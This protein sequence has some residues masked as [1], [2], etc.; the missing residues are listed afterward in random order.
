MLPEEVL[1]LRLWSGPMYVP[2]SAVLRNGEKGKYTNTLH[3]LDSAV[4]SLARIGFP[5]KVFR[6]IGVRAFKLE[7]FTRR[8][9][10][11]MGA[12][13][14]IRDQSV[15]R[16]YSTWDD[17]VRASYILEVQEGEA[18]KGADISPF[19]YYPQEQEKLY[20]PL[21]M[22][23]FIATRIEGSTL[24]LSM[25][26]NVNARQGTLTEAK[27]QKFRQTMDIA[28]NLGHDLQLNDAVKKLQ[29]QSRLGDFQSVVRTLKD[30][31]DKDRDSFNHDETFQKAILMTAE[32]WKGASAHAALH[33]QVEDVLSK[34]AGDES[35]AE[36]I[37]AAEA[38]LRQGRARL[39][40]PKL[41]R[42]LS[43]LRFMWSWGLREA[44]IFMFHVGLLVL[45][46]TS[47][48]PVVVLNVLNV[49]VSL[50][51]RV[52]VV[53]YVMQVL[54]ASPLATLTSRATYFCGDAFFVMHIKVHG[55]LGG[56]FNDMRWLLVHRDVEIAG[57]DSA[58]EALE[59]EAG[60]VGDGSESGG[61]SVGGACCLVV[62]LALPALL[63]AFAELQPWTTC[64][65]HSLPRC[66]R[67]VPFVPHAHDRRR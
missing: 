32:S 3:A 24:V 62:S 9:F 50:L 42:R 4:T 34:D 39:A 49:F 13:S 36:E 64:R 56:D 1:A 40:L 30:A 14:F 31:Q 20:G 26:V 2:Y 41:R 35:V 28:S 61:Q 19:S 46:V 58:V 22:M 23:Q 63:I 17:E 55:K 37:R 8:A 18:D 33:A 43:D 51:S 15:A 52:S 38:E 59:E 29:I 10:V 7:D 53:G 65:R 21:A 45:A 67:H 60:D 6:G 44:W 66:R 25:R 47:L 11:E 16:Q 12:Q 54:V 57:L 48:L 5:E 27:Q